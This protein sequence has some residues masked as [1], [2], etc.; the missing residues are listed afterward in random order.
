MLIFVYYFD[1]SFSRRARLDLYSI[2]VFLLSGKNK[3]NYQLALLNFP[4]ERR[5][6][7]L[8]LMI[9]F[10]FYMQCLL[11][12]PLFFCSIS[13]QI[14]AVGRK[15]LSELINCVDFREALTVKSVRT[16]TY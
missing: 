9:Y 14:P 11:L 2:T 3:E 12:K 10:L 6:N 8:L 1:I 13:R 15:H 4:E 16:A 5:S 7:Y